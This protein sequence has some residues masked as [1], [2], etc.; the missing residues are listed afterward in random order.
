MHVKD[1]IILFYLLHSDYIKPLAL[2][3]DFG[4]EFTYLYDQPEYEVISDEEYECGM[5]VSDSDS[6]DDIET[7][8]PS[9]ASPPGTGAPPAPQPTLKLS[10]AGG[11]PLAPPVPTV[12]ESSAGPPPAPPVPTVM[13]S[14]AGPPPVP[15][16]MESSAGP[17]PPPEGSAKSK[18][19]VGSIFSL[20]SS[21]EKQDAQPTKK[22]VGKW[23]QSDDVLHTPQQQQRKGRRERRA[24]TNIVSIKFNTLVMPS[25]MHTGDAVYCT[26]C[27]SILSHISEIKTEDD[28]KVWTCEFC[29][30]RNVIDVED[31]EVPKVDDVTF[32]LEPALSTTASGPKDGL[33]NVGLGRLDNLQSVDDE[34]AAGKFYEDIGNLAVSKGVCVSVTSIKGTNCKLVH[35]GKLADVTGGQV[36][37][38]DPLKLTQ[39]FST[40]LANNI[41]ATNVVAT[42]IIHKQLFFHFEET[43]ESK[44]VRN[45]GNVTADTEIT[46]EYGVRTKHRKAETEDTKQSETGD[47]KPDEQKPEESGATAGPSTAGKD[48]GPDKL[49]FQLQ[50]QYTD[51]DGAKALRVLTQVKPVTWDR[52]IAENKMNLDVLGKHTAHVSGQLAMEGLYT[53]SRSKALMNQ[54]LAWRF[55]NHSEEGRH[56]RKSYKA[57]FGKIKSVENH[58]NAVQMNERCSNSGRTY[59]D[60]EDS[61]A[62]DDVPDMKRSM[63]V[64]KSKKKLNRRVR[65]CS[66]EVYEAIYDCKDLSQFKKK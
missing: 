38:V 32:M 66:D 54:R 5:D 31:E 36:N 3:M 50:I 34:A 6:G 53:Q 41:I 63:L 37:I 59:S 22:K 11:I 55:T 58:I 48:K 39:E 17:P 25:N 57:M 28:S 56:H 52:K 26:S 46:F 49:P 8:K 13:E 62:E 43:E 16:V 60:S 30:E 19:K 64:K 18:S 9:A 42:F 12:M 61:D 33:A 23:R 51:T 10:C 24:D 45:I 1:L 21:K 44:V 27:R 40:I 15:T 7:V 29:G 47:T 20:F 65:E 35:L 2:K 4:S 14:S